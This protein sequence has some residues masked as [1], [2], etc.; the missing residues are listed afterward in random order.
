VAGAAGSSDSSD[1]KFAPMNLSKNDVR[2]VLMSLGTGSGDEM[3]FFESGAL[4]SWE[5]NIIALK[6]SSRK[7]ALI[8]LLYAIYGIPLSDKSDITVA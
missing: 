8:E 2:S 5:Q 7:I 1:G 6:A 4:L 3:Y